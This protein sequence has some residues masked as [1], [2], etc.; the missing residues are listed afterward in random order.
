M[1]NLFKFDINDERFVALKLK[2]Q[3]D[4]L[5]YFLHVNFE[6]K[7]NNRDYMTIQKLED[8]LQIDNQFLAIMVEQ[9]AAQKRIVEVK[10]IIMR[11]PQVI[12]LLSH[13]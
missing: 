11:N 10:D 4:A 13:D 8:I 12:N 7:V 1:L 5:S 6:G 9:L 3:Q 2:S